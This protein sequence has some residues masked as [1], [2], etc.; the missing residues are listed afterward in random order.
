[1]PLSYSRWRKRAKACFYLIFNSFFLKS[2]SWM[3]ACHNPSLG[4]VIKARAC[5]DASQKWSPIV[6]FHAPE[7]ARKCEGMNL[8]TPKWAPLWELESQ[9]TLK[10]S[11]GNYKGQNLLDWKVFYIIGKFLERKCLKWAHMTHLDNWNISYGK[12]KGQESFCQFDSR[13]LKVKNPPNFLA[14]RWCATYH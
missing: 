7:S 5:E 1:V 12:K 2:F 11:E 9:W 6:T 8:H 14:C 3:H 13:P 10:F 4:L